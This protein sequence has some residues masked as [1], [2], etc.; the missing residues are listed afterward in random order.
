[1]A[2]LQVLL[3]GVLGATLLVPMGASAQ[4]NRVAEA[5]LKEKNIVLPAETASL[6]NYVNAVQT[7]NL[8]YVSGTIAG[9]VR[10]SPCLRGHR[11]VFGRGRCRRSRTLRSGCPKRASGS[12]DFR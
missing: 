10:L 12:R 6:G 9:T 4:T 2:S 11:A 3:A 5:R 8:L 7:G 1:M